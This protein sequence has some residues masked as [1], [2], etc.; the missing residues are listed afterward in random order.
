MGIWGYVRRV[1]SKQLAEFLKSP[2]IL[3]YEERGDD[4][5]CTVEK[6]WNA[7][8]FLLIRLEESGRLRPVDPITGGTAFGGN[9]TY[10]PARYFLPEDVEYTAGELK[11]ISAKMLDE[12]FDPE[13]MEANH[14]YPGHWLDQDRDW[15][16]KYVLQYFMAMAKY[17]RE[18]A[19][20]GDAM[21]LYFG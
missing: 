19:Q 5:D 12:V 20:A 6:T 8:E 4:T 11:K 3:V 18:A 7:I 21:L 15:L 1:N 14:V 9:L 2:E 16:F 17:Y 13:D 10:G